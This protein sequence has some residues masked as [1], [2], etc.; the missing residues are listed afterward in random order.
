MQQRVSREDVKDALKTRASTDEVERL[1]E[2]Q[3]QS[4]HSLQ[5]KVVVPARAV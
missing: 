5:Q 3:V 1:F 2:R 4:M